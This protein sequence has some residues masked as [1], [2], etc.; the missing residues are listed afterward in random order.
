MGKRVGG[1]DGCIEGKNEGR[2]EG[3]VVDGEEVG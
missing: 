3:W 1:I 2:D